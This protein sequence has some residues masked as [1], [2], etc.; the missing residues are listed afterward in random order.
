MKSNQIPTVKDCK[1]DTYQEMKGVELSWDVLMD[2]T[3]CYCRY[4]SVPLS[5]LGLILVAEIELLECIPLDLAA[6]SMPL[7][8]P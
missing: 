6:F 3:H 1:I 5:Y 8:L 7:V 2:T 4:C